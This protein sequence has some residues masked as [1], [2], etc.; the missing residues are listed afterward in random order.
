MSVLDEIIAKKKLELQALKEF[1]DEDTLINYIELSADE[2]RGFVSFLQ[3]RVKQG[4]AA[5]IAEAKKAAPSLG[6]LRQ[7][8]IPQVIGK[9][10]EAN[11]AT[12]LSVCTEKSFYQGSIVHLRKIRAA[13]KLPILRMDFLIDEYQVI[14]SRAIGADCVLLVA[15]LLKNDEL[16]TMTRL[17]YDLGMDVLIETHNEIEIKRV[18]SANL[19]IHM[20][21]I[22]NRTFGG[23]DTNINLSL[24]LVQY[25]PRDILVVSQSGIGSREDIKRLRASGIHCFLIGSALMKAENP[26]LELKKLLEE[27][28]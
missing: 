20:I 26:A 1:I 23:V 25:V 12:C 13:S 15:A 27:E 3:R 18:L 28:K 21:G 7:S 24:D 22:N 11:G 10:F 2:P 9:N 17:A 4:K 16:L 5:I 14:E 19:P 8:Y 6:V